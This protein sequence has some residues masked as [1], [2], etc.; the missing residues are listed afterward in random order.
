MGQYLADARLCHLWAIHMD[1]DISGTL[2]VWRPRGSFDAQHEFC[3]PFLLST[4]LSHCPASDHSGGCSNVRQAVERSAAQVDPQSK[5][6]P[7]S[8]RRARARGKNKTFSPSSYTGELLCLSALGRSSAVAPTMYLLCGV[9]NYPWYQRMRRANF[10][11]LRAALQG[12]DE[13]VH[14]VHAAL[15]KMVALLLALLRILEDGD[16]T[17]SPQT[18]NLLGKSE[19]GWL[20]VTLQGDCLTTQ[21]IQPIRHTL[22]NP[23]SCIALSR[24]CHCQGEP[25]LRL[26]FY[27]DRVAP[28]TCR[29]QR[30]SP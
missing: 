26:S 22:R 15:S 19:N 16:A 10:C 17:L 9:F 25:I 30:Y 18:P 13:A 3:V 27:E 7:K 11:R 1:V 23:W 14:D 5:L 12:S 8:P 20:V 2:P 24:N 6:A 28:L 4:E 21:P 29:I